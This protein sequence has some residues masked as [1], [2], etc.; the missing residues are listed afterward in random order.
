MTLRLRRESR[1]EPRGRGPSRW[2]LAIG[3]VDDLQSLDAGAIVVENPENNLYPV[4]AYL[5][6][7]RLDE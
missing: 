6:R 1:E 5:V 7:T 4:V 2:H 3:S